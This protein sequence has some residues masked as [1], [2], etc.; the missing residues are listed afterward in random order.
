[1][2]H[3]GTASALIGTLN[4]AGGAVVVAMELFAEARRGRRSRA[5]RPARGVA[6][7]LGCTRCI[8]DASE[9]LIYDG[10]DPKMPA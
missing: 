4:F 6:F 2:D 10:V 5:S 7:M 9:I 8:A 1:M 3:P